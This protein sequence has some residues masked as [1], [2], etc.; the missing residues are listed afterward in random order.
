MFHTLK[1]I[2][3]IVSFRYLPTCCLCFIVPRVFLQSC[4]IKEGNAFC[5][6]SFVISQ[7]TLILKLNVQKYIPASVILLYNM[8]YKLY[9]ICTWKP[10]HFVMMNMS[11]KIDLA[12]RNVILQSL[13][14]N[15][16]NV[17]KCEASD[18][19]CWVNDNIFVIS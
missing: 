4:N 10:F 9:S 5:Q 8:P 16:T 19:E 15:R 3:F 2:L 17:T 18:I 13:T 11:N 7:A 1:V 6:F 12:W 14:M